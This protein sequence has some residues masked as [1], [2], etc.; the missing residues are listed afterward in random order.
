MKSNINTNY[1][2]LARFVGIYAVVLGHFT[3]FIGVGDDIGRKLLY[4]FHVPLFFV[5]SG[6]LSKPTPILKSFY[7]LMIPYLIYNIISI[8]K[9]DFK[10]LFT[11]DALELNNSPTWFFPALFFIKTIA[12]YI[13]KKIPYLIA[14]IIAGVTLLYYFDIEIP[15]LFGLHAV[16]YGLPFFLLGKFIKEKMEVILSVGVG[17]LFCCGIILLSACLCNK[18][19]DLYSS[20]IH[21]PIV[22]FIS[23]GLASI[24]I[25]AIC[26]RIFIYIPKTL[27]RFIYTNS[28]GTMFILG[29][30]YIALGVLSKYIIPEVHLSFLLKTLIVALSSIPYYY[31]IR[32]T[33][34]KC[35]IL[36]GR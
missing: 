26:N 13:H 31:I 23:S 14:I 6:M 10:A 17:T 30:H 7:S 5:V 21:N 9:M 36:Y 33:Y 2:D 12:N 4:A 32:Y 24:W 22:Y 25:L 1:I 29:T 3:P 19:F 16:I 8:I 27:H 11:F 15:R 35:P 20:Q 34:N 28:R 18:R